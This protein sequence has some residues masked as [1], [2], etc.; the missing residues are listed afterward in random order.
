MS[1]PNFFTSIATDS[2]VK[3]WIIPNEVFEWNQSIDKDSI[4]ID[5][6]EIKKAR[7]KF[8]YDTPLL[9]T[10]DMLEEDSSLANCIQSGSNSF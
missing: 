10:K 2:T 1:N 9:S 6:K 3:V 4:M 5:E 8:K 7:K